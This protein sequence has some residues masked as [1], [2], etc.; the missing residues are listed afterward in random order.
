MLMNLRFR[1]PLLRK[2]KMMVNMNDSQNKDKQLGY[3]LLRRSIV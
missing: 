1:I 3:L 2:T